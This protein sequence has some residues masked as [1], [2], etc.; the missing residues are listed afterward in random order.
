MSTTRATMSRTPRRARSSCTDAR[1]WVID[2]TNAAS[3]E[4][5]ALQKKMANIRETLATLIT[6]GDRNY[7]RVMEYRGLIVAV[8]REIDQKS[9]L[10]RLTGN[11][12]PDASPR[13]APDGTRLVLPLGTF[14]HPNKHTI[15]GTAL[16]VLLITAFFSV[17]PKLAARIAI[18]ALGN[19]RR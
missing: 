8:Q 6:D 12:G 3:A 18:R 16:V 15:L 19:H 14:Q 2:V 11:D 9:G 17:G 13:W 4:V 10:R 1:I 5:V 7:F